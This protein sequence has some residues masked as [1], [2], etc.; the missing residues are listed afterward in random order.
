MINEVIKD[1][2]LT[3]EQNNIAA[4]REVFAQ[5][6]RDGVYIESMFCEGVMG[7]GR[8]GMALD[9][10]F[11]KEA[12]E[13]TRKHGSFLVVDSIQAGLRCTGNLSLV[14]YP[15]FTELPP[16]DFEVWAKAINAGQYPCSLVGMAAEGAEWY[17]HGV[18]GNT[19]TG[20]PRACAVAAAVL[21]EITPAL[22]KNVVEMGRYAVEQ[23]RKLQVEF[24][25][26]IKEVNGT[27]MLYAVTLNRD[28]LAVVASDGAEMWLRRN[29]V[30]VIHGG[31]NALRFTPNLNISK[32]E[33]DMQ[34]HHVRQFLV[35]TMGALERNPVLKDLDS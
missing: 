10:A 21:G 30:N 15:G 23:Y 29:G 17:R 18:Y 1:Y 7:E 11:Y 12:R 19:M 31:D 20:N 9:P 13:L 5:A 32:E 2:K 26:A 28:R 14:D 16:P 3:V 25:D 33:L 6:E 27:G 8:P 24:P 34:I 22:R 4:L 35:I